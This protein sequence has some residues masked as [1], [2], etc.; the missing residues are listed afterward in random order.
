M[1]GNPGGANWG[2]TAAN[3]TNGLVFVLGTN[4]P[5]LLKLEKST[6]G[7][8][9]ASSSFGPPNARGGRGGG[10]AAA[11]PGR[12]LYV[13]NC[14]SCH[15]ADL[16][17][18]A[19]PAL[20][21]VTTKMGADAIKGIIAAGKGFMPAFSALTE[22]EKESI[23]TFL[24]NP[25]A[26]APGGG[27]G[28]GG[29]TNAGPLVWLGGPVV[30]SGPAP[31]SLTPAPVI[32]GESRALYGGNGGI[33]AYPEGVEVPDQRY[34]SGYGLGGNAVKP[35]WSTVTAYDLNK[36]TIKW[37]VPAGDDPVLAAQGIHKTGARGLRT[38]IVPTATG[39]VFLVGGDN[40]VHA[41]DE[42]N[43]NELWTHD[44]AGGS[45][46]SPSMYE[47]DGRAYLVIAISGPGTVGRGGQAQV[48]VDPKY[49]NLPSG[50]VVFALPAK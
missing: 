45:G 48:P 27:G 1:P 23:L 29:A 43:G 25:N 26:G 47:I 44:I 17:G 33:F 3:P 31:P 22:V 12:G 13:Q 40:K 19:G 42:D 5:A 39:L 9:G 32:P 34:N 35:P 37:Q 8:T 28:R 2:V 50:Y 24:A 14:Q 20:A 6:P 30:E 18:G 46:A 4:A 21:A 15:G 10:N 16:T 49:A 41:Y 38:G 7:G 36:G 11:A